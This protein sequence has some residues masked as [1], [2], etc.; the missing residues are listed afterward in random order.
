MARTGGSPTKVV[1]KR[2]PEPKRGR[3]L[4]V[5]KDL[6]KPLEDSHHECNH[7]HGHVCRDDPALE[8]DVYEGLDASVT[9]LIHG[10]E[11]DWIEQ[12]MSDDDD[13]KYRP[14]YDAI[15]GNL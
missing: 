14:L 13:F 15:N 6:T 10:L 4:S 3:M 2:K 11:S 7:G 5:S 8:E 9:L 12:E 1:P